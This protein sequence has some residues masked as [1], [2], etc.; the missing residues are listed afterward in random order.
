M[1]ILNTLERKYGRY[2]PENLTKILLIGQVVSYVL[3]Y[4]RPELVSYFHLT[5]RQ[6]FQGQIWRLATI[7]FAPVSESMFFVIFVWYFFYL[8][9]TA[10]ENQWGS[11]RYLI[12][13]SIAYLAM[14]VFSLFFPD[15]QVTNTYIY[16]TLFLA[17]AQ[18]NPNFQLLLFFIIPVKVKWLGYFAWFGLIASFLFGSLPVKVLTLLSVS[19]FFLFFHDDLRF[20]SLFQGVSSR[21]KGR[22]QK[23]KPMHVCAV[24]GH[25]EIDNPD[26]E[27]RYCNQCIP[28]TCYCGEHV[29]QHQHKRVV[30]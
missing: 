23:Q 12:Y 18:L 14:I 13:I 9:G 17:F 22:L 28:T 15:I 29:T 25:N 19:N 21:S 1:A 8:F 24:C 26:M 20:G 6:F 30:N 7:L 2:V 16:T 4:A 27:I 11:F 3:V 10:L 5:G